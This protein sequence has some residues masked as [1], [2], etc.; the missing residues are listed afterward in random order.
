M[1]E[2][3][4]KQKS[5][6]TQDQLGGGII[7]CTQNVAICKIYTVCKFFLVHQSLSLGI[8]IQIGFTP[9]LSLQTPCV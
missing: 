2:I 3:A 4:T 7:L 6:A 5:K 9:Q 8:Q 1:G